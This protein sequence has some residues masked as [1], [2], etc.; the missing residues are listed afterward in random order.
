MSDIRFIYILLKLILFFIFCCGGF[1][2]SKT[3]TRRS[4]WTTAI[5]PILAF[6]IVEGLRFGRLIDYN[7]Y[8]FR[9]ID[10]GQGGDQFYEL[11]FSVICYVLYNCGIPYH[12]FIFLQCLFLIY[13]TLLFFENYKG[14]VKYALPIV[15]GLYILNENFI[16]WYLAFS[17]ILL[18][19]N[20]TIKE[21]K[22]WAWIWAI[23]G[24]LTH[25]GFFFYLIILLGKGLLNR[26][27]IKPI[28]STGLVL[29]STF[30]ITITEIGG[31]IVLVSNLFL[32]L[33]I[34]SLSDGLN[35]R[36]SQSADLVSG[37][38][39]TMGMM[40][41]SF[42]GNIRYILSCL[43]GIYWGRKYM[44]T[45]KNGIYIYNLFI[46]GAIFNPLLSMVEMLGRISSSLL[47]FLSIVS[48]VVFIKKL[49]NRS[50]IV[51]FILCL[52]SFLSS[53]WPSISIAFAYSRDI[54][55]MFIWDANG[56]NYLPY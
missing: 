17:F 33:G 45:Y 37:Y 22:A 14:A 50:H 28:I 47:M 3:T 36:L 55:M 5:I 49:N 30:F 11:M 42:M 31:F 2:L 10:I 38:V 26:V 35:I 43:P 6:A 20:S 12:I 23:C 4:Y 13:A 29:I 48:G 54:D 7:L 21:K 18:S 15:L 44:Q 27:T 46:I 39:G 56:R 53:C 51:I 24:V 8:Y 16:R 41:T 32:K 40:E 1:M 52:L 34:G 9:Y 19:I 25:F